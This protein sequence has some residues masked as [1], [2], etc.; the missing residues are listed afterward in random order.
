MNACASALRQKQKLYIKLC[1]WLTRWVLDVWSL[2]RI[3][4][5]WNKQWWMARWIYHC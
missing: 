4:W 2:Q 3:A 5:L 1:S